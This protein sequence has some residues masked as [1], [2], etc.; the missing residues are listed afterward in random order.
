MDFTL[1]SNFTYVQQQVGASAM[2]DVQLML[3]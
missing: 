3:Y 1:I 2:Q